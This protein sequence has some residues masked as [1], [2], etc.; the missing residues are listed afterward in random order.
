MTQ[1]AT[2]TWGTI[3]NESKSNLNVTLKP[4]L[5]KGIGGVQGQ[6]LDCLS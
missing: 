4:Q 6:I 5:L 3:M 2:N 1:T